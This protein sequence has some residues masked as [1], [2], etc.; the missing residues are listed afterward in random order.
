MKRTA[1]ALTFI[2]ALLFSVVSG[3]GFVTMAGA[4]PIGSVPVP[5]PSIGIG[6][7]PDNFTF[8][9]STVELE[10]FVR[11]PCD[12]PR[13]KSISYNLDGK[14]LVYFENLTCVMVNTQQQYYASYI[15]WV[16][17]E[18]LSEG[19]HTVIAYAND[20]FISYHFAVNLHPQVSP[21]QTPDQ[22]S[23]QTPQIRQQSV[24]VLVFRLLYVG[25]IVLIVAL[26]ILVYFKKRKH[27][28]A[29]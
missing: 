19:N 6:L 14:P 7:L 17:L 26:G 3:T 20:M 9:T 8:E 27:V 11:L 5:V 12:A 2:V 29:K 16:S 18:N 22:N 4:N 21:T 1:L 24:A 25:I 13:L 10:I 15:V 28:D 23:Q